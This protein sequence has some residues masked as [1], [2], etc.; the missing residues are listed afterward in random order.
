MNGTAEIELREEFRNGQAPVGVGGEV[1]LRDNAE[2]PVERF[3]RDDRRPVR[4]RLVAHLKL[5]RTQI[6]AI[7]R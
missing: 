4:A 6:E 5:E 7:S 3:G 1:I 2:L